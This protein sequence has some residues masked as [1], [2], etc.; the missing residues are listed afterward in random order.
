MNVVYAL[1]VKRLRGAVVTKREI[2]E[3]KAKKAFNWRSVTK[4]PVYYWHIILIEFI[5]AAVW[6]SFQTISTDLVQVHFGTTQVLA[7]YTASASLVV[8]IVAT[9]LLGFFMDFFGGRLIILLISAI[10]MILSAALLG[11]TYVNAVVGMVFYSISLAFGP[12]SMITSIG[13]LLPSDYI[14]T[15]LGMYKSS[16]NIGTSILDIVVGVV[17]DNTANQ[18]Y[19]GVMALFIA[20]SVIGFILI[21]MLWLTQRVYLNNLL[22]VGRKK[23]TEQMEEIND[24]QLELTRQGLDPYVNTKSTILNYV[25]IGIFVAALITAWVLFFVYALGGQI[26]V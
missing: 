26:A 24:A 20:L 4:F 25:Y 12:I 2:M 16:N 10:F 6:S 19:T 18:A 5:F 3:L 14:G 23:R 9:P 17:Q 11:W 8:P 1:V 13:M 15:G 7:A 21:A 22:E